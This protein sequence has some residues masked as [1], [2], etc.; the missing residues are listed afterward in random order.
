MRGLAILC[1]AIAVIYFLGTII[2]LVASIFVAGI[3]VFVLAILGAIFWSAGHP[4]D[5]GD[6][7]GDDPFHHNM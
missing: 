3:T 6:S 2:G 1:W 7:D 4:D 5:I